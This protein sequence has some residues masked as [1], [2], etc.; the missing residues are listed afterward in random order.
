VVICASGRRIA[1]D[2]PFVSTDA[3]L[4][5]WLSRTDLP[6]AGNCGIAVRPT[7]QLLDDDHVFA[8]GDCATMTKDSRPR[9]GVFAV[10]QGAVLAHNLMAAACGEPLRPYKPQKDYLTILRTGHGSAI[11]ARGGYFAVEGSWVW[12]LKDRIDQAFM[13]RFKVPD[14]TPDPDRADMRCGGCAAKVGPLPL[15]QALARLAPAPAHGDVLVG[16][17]APDD[18]AVVR[19][20][21]GANLI[22]SVDQFRAFI[23]DAYLF[24]RIAANHALNDVYAMGGTPHHALALA[25]LP[26]N[27]PAKISEELFQ[28]LS[29]A[30]AT[31]DAAQTPLVGG[32]S[33]EGEALAL[34][35]AVAGKSGPPC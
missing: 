5:E 34:G 17:D 14:M 26:Y 8:A 24:G 6:K 22:A 10:R 29:G 31:L 12:R 3:Q 20:S 27:K 16:L 21:K 15:A 25:I 2:V 18:A 13:A 11:A 28:L 19:W 32:H 7:L 30:R 9:A 1:I 23:D 4:P 33:S 35:F